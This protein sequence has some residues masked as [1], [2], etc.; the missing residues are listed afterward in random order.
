MRTFI[1]PCVIAVNISL[2]WLMF[3]KKDDD[4]R[5]I[6]RPMKVATRLSEELVVTVDIVD[7]MTTVCAG[8]STKRRRRHR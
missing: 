3:K 8:P 4:G 7:Y 1:K 2:S 6:K 5:V